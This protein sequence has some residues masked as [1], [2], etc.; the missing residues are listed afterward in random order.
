MRREQARTRVPPN[1]NR[2][3]LPTALLRFFIIIQFIGIGL[4]F[5]VPPASELRSELHKADNL[6]DKRNGFDGCAKDGKH[7]YW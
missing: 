4:G 3:S 7:R 2:D 5:S 6:T 1:G